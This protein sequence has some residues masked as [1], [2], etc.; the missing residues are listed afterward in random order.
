[1][2][3]NT[4]RPKHDPEADLYLPARLVSIPHCQYRWN[5]EAHDAATPI[6]TQSKQA[7]KLLVQDLVKPAPG[8]TTPDRLRIQ[9]LVPTIPTPVILYRC[10]DEP[11]FPTAMHDMIDDDYRKNN[12][13]VQT[14]PKTIDI[15]PAWHRDLDRRDHNH[16]PRHPDIEAARTRRLFT[17]Q[18]HDPDTS[19]LWHT[20][21]KHVLFRL[22]YAKPLALLVAGYLT[23]CDAMPY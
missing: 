18:W 13:L 14:L 22:A 5:S 2:P 7:L 9:F 21:A 11:D 1:L 17:A 10:L 15:S 8:R 6:D 12:T 16:N 3:Y 19:I 20:A 4:W 23:G